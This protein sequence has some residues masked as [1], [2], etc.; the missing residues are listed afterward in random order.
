MVINNIQYNMQ[1]LL[2][3]FPTGLFVRISWHFQ[4]FVHSLYSLFKSWLN[5]IIGTF[6]NDLYFIDSSYKNRCIIRSS[7]AEAI[8][9]LIILLA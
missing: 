8:L 5:T 2:E 9:C 4:H 1:N 7:Y 3:Y 6:T